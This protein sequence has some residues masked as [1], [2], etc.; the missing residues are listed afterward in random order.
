MGEIRGEKIVLPLSS[1]LFHF[2]PP[3]LSSRSTGS[4]PLPDNSYPKIPIKKI[5]TT[6]A[7]F[8]LVPWH[9][10]YLKKKEYLTSV[11]FADSQIWPLPCR[12]T[13]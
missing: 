13:P 5:P 1:P 4:Q 8:L 12:A 3:F 7:F 2:L 10:P 6:N 9:K 11:C